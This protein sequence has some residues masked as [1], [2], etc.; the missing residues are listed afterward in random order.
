MSDLQ[1]LQS[2]VPETCRHCEAAPAVSRFGLCEHCR[3][4]RGIRQLY[5][6]R[7]GWT[8]E[9]EAH[10][11]RLRRHA[12]QKLPLFDGPLVVGRPRDARIHPLRTFR[13]LSDVAV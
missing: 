9:F 13:P 3:S 2:A 5:L 10:L 8:P 11:M 7:R 6:R 12:E 4:R 1:S